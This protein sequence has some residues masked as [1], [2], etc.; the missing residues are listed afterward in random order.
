MTTADDDMDPAWLQKL[1]GDLKEL[2][3]T[4]PKVA[5]AKRKYDQAAKKVLSLP[6]PAALLAL[7]RAAQVHGA[8]GAETPETLRGVLLER[9]EVVELRAAL[10]AGTVTEADVARWVAL[11]L[12]VFKPGERFVHER[13]FCAL[14][15][16]L[17]GVPTPSALGFLD[18]MAASQAHELTMLPKVAQEC[19]KARAEQK[20]DAPVAGLQLVSQGTCQCGVQYIVIRQDGKDST[21]HKQPTCELFDKTGRVSLNRR[22]QR[23]LEARRRK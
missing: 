7:D 3:K 12:Q 21:R 16:A 20:L 10:V 23:A 5:E 19:L 13:A 17:E 8:F 11:R 2:E 14:V 1:E 6:L 9:P 4:D 22:E 15:V 18:N